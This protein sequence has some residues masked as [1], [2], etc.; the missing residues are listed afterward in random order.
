MKECGSAAH[1]DIEE[2]EELEEE[3]EDAAP[4]D[5]AAPTD[6]AATEDATEQVAPAA[7]ASESPAKRSAD[8]TAAAKGPQPIP[9]EVPPVAGASASIVRPETRA[10]RFEAE[11]A[12]AAAGKE[13][14]PAAGKE[15][16][17]DE[18][19]RK[20]RETRRAIEFPA[21]LG[22]KKGDGK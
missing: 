7:G 5:T 2:E 8:G 12:K 21:E 17:A 1:A 19:G 20:R 13:G 14:G 22:K 18:G 6:T 15:G 9:A 16:A 11:A 3:M 4:A 10:K